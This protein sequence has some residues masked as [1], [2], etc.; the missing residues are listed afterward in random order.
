MDWAW[1]LL[2]IY[3]RNE[4]G[5]LLISPVQC[6]YMYHVCNHQIFW[7]KLHHTFLVTCCGVCFVVVLLLSR[8]RCCGG[9]HSRG[10]DESS[11]LYCGAVLGGCLYGGANGSKDGMSGD[12][13]AARLSWRWIEAWEVTRVYWRRDWSCIVPPAVSWFLLFFSGAV[14]LSYIYSLV[15]CYFLYTERSI[16]FFI[17][18]HLIIKNMF[19]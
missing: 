17:V 3:P 19:I 18:G 4:T 7:V 6:L 1:Y 16:G 2:L 8:Q 11:L 14:P 10:Y 15:D 12:W 13:G 9:P 5:C